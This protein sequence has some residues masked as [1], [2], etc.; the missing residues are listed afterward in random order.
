MPK[1]GRGPPTAKLVQARAVPEAHKR[2]RPVMVIRRER[3]RRFMGSPCD[4]VAVKKSDG[5]LFVWGV[6]SAL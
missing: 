1:I 6:G 3:V 5:L 4:A 2:A